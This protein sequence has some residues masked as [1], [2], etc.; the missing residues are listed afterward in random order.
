MENGK[1]VNPQLTFLSITKY[2]E[3][4]RINLDAA[5]GLVRH[6]PKNAYYMVQGGRKPEWGM[7][8]PRDFLVFD[9]TTMTATFSI[10]LMQLASAVKFG[11]GQGNFKD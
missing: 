10:D 2:D 8:C 4:S 3:I 1:T 6:S 9:S 5:F 7:F 11:L